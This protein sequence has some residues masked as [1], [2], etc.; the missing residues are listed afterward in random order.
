MDALKGMFGGADN[1]DSL[2]KEDEESSSLINESTPATS[3]GS[4]GVFSQA[5]DMAQKLETPPDYKIAG[6]FLIFSVL[7]FFAAFTSLPLIIFN[8]SS[9]N[10]YF[11]FG[12]IFL[13]LAMAF[14][15]APM[16][17]LRKLFAPETRIISGIYIG[18]LL[19]DLYFLFAGAG[20]LL[21]LILVG[22]N[23]CTLAWFVTQTL[24]GPEMA[25]NWAY[26]MV[27]GQMV[28]KAKNLIGKGGDG[29]NG[30]LPI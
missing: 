23:G 11:C 6:A 30:S 14:F 22:I 28:N 10:L 15:Y 3:A 24:G 20:Y 17:Y 13:Q 9:F 2:S 27:L 16:V 29:G 7:F 5:E 19:I 25:N 26:A 12:S 8:P 21:T 1:K 18:S 4:G